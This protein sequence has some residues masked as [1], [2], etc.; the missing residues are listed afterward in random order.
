MDLAPLGFPPEES[1]ILQG[2]CSSRKLTA[3]GHRSHF[4]HLT[5]TFSLVFPLPGLLIP[6]AYPL[7]SGGD[8]GEGYGALALGTCH[9]PGEAGCEATWKFD[10]HS[11]SPLPPLLF[12]SP[13]CCQL[14]CWRGIL[15]SNRNVGDRAQSRI[16]RQRPSR[17][18]LSLPLR[19]GLACLI[20]HCSHIFKRKKLLGPYYRLRNRL[21]KEET[22]APESCMFLLS[23]W[24]PRAT[25]FS[26]RSF[27]SLCRE[28]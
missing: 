22:S 27:W 12:T 1:C 23:C 11:L 7:S 21:R 16:K 19:P 5:R 10:F 26:K 6:A 2:V 8:W 17:R 25:S 3:R 18:E 15:N 28:V 4:L 24:L 13:F 20:L 14:K 9:I